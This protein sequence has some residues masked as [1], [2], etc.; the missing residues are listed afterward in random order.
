MNKG[1]NDLWVGLSKE[2]RAALVNRDYTGASLA[3][4][5]VGHGVAAA[6]LVS[7]EAGVKATVWIPG[8]EIFPRQIH[9][10]R[11]RGL[12]GEFARQQEGLL[13]QIGL[14][15]KQWATARMFARTAKGFH[16]HPP[17]IPGGT[18][19]AQWHRRLFVDEPGNYALRRYAN[20]QWDMMFFVQ[21]RIEMILRDV[22]DGLESRTMHFYIDGDN[23]PSDS[24]V[25]VVIPAGVAHA[26]R[27]EGSEDAIM[28]YGTSTSFHPEFE[29]RIASEVE[30]AELPKAWQKFLASGD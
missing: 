14:W 20:E 4:R 6:E 1:S 7:V 30:T 8:V 26:L 23:H 22:R 25:G 13:A 5:L 17:S 3:A 28:V 21:G 2:A 19:A 16:V 15:P 29:G 9:R 27:V 18:S 24:N 11:Q 12:F 10:Q